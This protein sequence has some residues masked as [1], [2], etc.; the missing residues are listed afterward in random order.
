[1]LMVPLPSLSSCLKACKEQKQGVPGNAEVCQNECRPCPPMQEPQTVEHIHTCHTP[2]PPFVQGD[3]SPDHCRHTPRVLNLG[4]MNNP[5]H[6]LRLKHSRECQWEKSKH[7][8]AAM[9]TKG[10]AVLLKPT[11]S[12]LPPH[13]RCYHHISSARHC[14]TL[15][16][17]HSHNLIGREWDAGF[18]RPT[19]PCRLEL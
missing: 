14:S 10:R 12:Y 17:E 2:P 16:L 8:E 3:N 1:M 19:P 6:T 11:S 15:L 13:T 4:L 9:A 18:D 7:S 5:E